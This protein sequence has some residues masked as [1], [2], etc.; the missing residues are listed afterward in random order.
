MSESVEREA[1]LRQPSALEGWL[2]GRHA[3]LVA[4]H[5]RRPST[6]TEEEAVALVVAYVS[7]DASWIDETQP[8]LLAVAADTANAS[9]GGFDLVGWGTLALAFGT[10]YMAL[11]TRRAARAAETEVRQSHR[12][13]ETAQRQ[14]DAA[15]KQVIASEAQAQAAVQALEASARPLLVPASGLEGFDRR[16]QYDFIANGLHSGRLDAPAVACWHVTNPPGTMISVQ[17]V[18]LKVRNVGNGPA[19][20]DSGPT[21]LRLRA[22]YGNGDAYGSTGA[23]VVGR[24]EFS[25]L[26]FSD[27]RAAEDGGPLASSLALARSHPDAVNA[28]TIAV[29]Y[30]DLGRT[31]WTTTHVKMKPLPGGGV[32]VLDVE[33]DP[34]DAT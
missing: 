33:I 31:R 28:F 16:E 32:S 4:A 19:V 8:V 2:P 9:T 6:A 29:R 17:W 14:V 23:L 30:A 11:Q 34:P 18:I 5:H 24:D 13:T 25:Y 3:E 21:G 10:F 15:E 12:L 7:A 27:T 1:I 26:V 20:I 22:M